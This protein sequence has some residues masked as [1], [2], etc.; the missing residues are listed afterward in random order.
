MSSI[1]TVERLMKGAIDFHVHA[2][3][4]PFHERRLDVINL[5]HQAK[6]I[7]MK[8][9]VAKCHHFGTGPSHFPVNKIVSGFTLVG[10]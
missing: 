7:G 9:I 3:P 6:E 4:D 1:D 8:A 10:P 2:G 5:A